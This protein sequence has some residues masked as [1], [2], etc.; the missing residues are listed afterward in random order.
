MN[1]TL[2][3]LLL[4][5]L[6]YILRVRPLDLRA[7]RETLLLKFNLVAERYASYYL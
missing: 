5:L 6:P 3:K 7:L 1:S 4:S 2:I